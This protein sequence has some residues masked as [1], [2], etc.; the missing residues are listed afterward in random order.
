[1]IDA[2]KLGPKF[3]HYKVNFTNCS[4]AIGTALRSPVFNLILP[5]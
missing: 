1:L 2:V 4:I 3:N 5:F